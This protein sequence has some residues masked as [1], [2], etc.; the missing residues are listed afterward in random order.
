MTG[1]CAGFGSAYGAQ[2]DLQTFSEC[3]ALC[4]EVAACTGIEFAPG[5]CNINTCADRRL[6]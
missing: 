3:T 5:N 1:D 4:D 2:L 6:T